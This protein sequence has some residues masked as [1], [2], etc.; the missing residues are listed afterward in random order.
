[1]KRVYFLH[2]LLLFFITLTISCM[3]SQPTNL[4]PPISTHAPTSAPT[5]P[6]EP[7]INFTSLADILLS[8]PNDSIDRSLTPQELYQRISGTD[9]LTSPYP[10]VLPALFD[11]TENDFV[12]YGEGTSAILIDRYV[13]FNSIVINAH[14]PPSA[15]NYPQFK[16]KKVKQGLILQVGLR[17][18]GNPEYE[19]LHKSVAKNADDYLEIFERNLNPEKQFPAAHIPFPIQTLSELALESEKES[20][21]PLI[22]YGSR[23]M[24]HEDYVLTK[25]I[26]SVS[27]VNRAEAT[28][29]INGTVTNSDYGGKVFAFRCGRPKL[30][31]IMIGS[32]QT[33]GRETEA[34][35]VGIEEILRF[36]KEKTGITVTVLSE[37]TCPSQNQRLNE[38]FIEILEDQRYDFSFDLCAL[39]NCNP[40]DITLWTRPFET[41]YERADDTKSE[42]LFTKGHAFLI[43]AYVAVVTPVLYSPSLAVSTLKGTYRHRIL[44]GGTLE[45]KEDEDIQY[46][47]LNFIG[48]DSASQIA[49]FKRQEGTKFPLPPPLPRLRL[50]KTNELTFG[51]VLFTTGIVNASLVSP[52]P[53][54]TFS[55]NPA[56]LIG[57]S[58]V[59]SAISRFYIQSAMRK[60]DNGQ[61]VSA[62]RDGKWE[63]V[64]IVYSSLGNQRDETL[65]TALPIEF[66]M[67]AVQEI[68]KAH[69][70][71]LSSKIL[72]DDAID[73]H[74]MNLRVQEG[75]KQIIALLKD[76]KLDSSFLLAEL[77]STDFT[78]LLVDT[79]ELELMLLNE[80]GKKIEGTNTISQ[81]AIILSDD[82]ILTSSS[83]ISSLLPPLFTL[84][85]AGGLVSD[86]SDITSNLVL[87]ID[88]EQATEVRVSAVLID[89][90]TKEREILEVVLIDRENGYALFRRLNPSQNFSLFPKKIGI[91]TNSELVTDN[92]FFIV[93]SKTLLDGS[94]SRVPLLFPGAISYGSSRASEFIVNGFV[95]KENIGS[96]I[97]CLNDGAPLLCAIVGNTSPFVDQIQTE[98]FAVSIHFIFEK[99][100]QKTDIDLAKEFNRK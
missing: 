60:E 20:P 89:R 59:S 95:S 7:P 16:D 35:V 24:P 61:L 37:E 25:K 17:P 22:F 86:T 23:F 81:S 46:E 77:L 30:V 15:E 55:E 47:Y 82:Y 69:S 2:A 52:K 49:L 18:D 44:W 78:S 87:A 41:V 28:I 84:S 94:L 6:Q 26:A 79:Y 58:R 91:A 31:G 42:V 90:V 10:I 50:G 4:S 53:Y 13:L 63:L 75:R 83:A 76:E 97:F 92:K 93:Y 67:N 68:L 21:I 9:I 64:G 45:N 14:T 36:L 12:T 5:S 32:R 34:F 51:N 19:V 48:V 56:T 62:L 3:K 38:R 65:N 70:L 57:F 54:L 66:F 98:G 40:Y 71:S 27:A 80:T 73:N 99:I 85:Q 100:K 29:A 72:S 96:P 39:K 8:Y 11:E 43:D 1:M 74:K 33:E 88:K